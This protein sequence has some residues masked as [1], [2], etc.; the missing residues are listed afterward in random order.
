MSTSLYRSIG[1]YPAIPTL[2]LLAILTD[3]TGQFK[4]LT[5]FGFFNIV[6]YLQDWSMTCSFEHC[7]VAQRHQENLRFLKQ[8]LTEL[9]VGA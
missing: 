8:S 6:L 2:F 7:W 3:E 4:G 5:V 1:Y 9:R